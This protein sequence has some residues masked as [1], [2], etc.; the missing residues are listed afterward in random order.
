M[1]DAFPHSDAYRSGFDEALAVAIAIVIRYIEGRSR[2]GD[3]TG[4][5]KQFES[6]AKQDCE[7]GHRNP[8]AVGRAEGIRRILK[9]S[10]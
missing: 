9:E 2:S 6:T 4:D 10:Y 5:L 8:R 1:S 7:D 3:L